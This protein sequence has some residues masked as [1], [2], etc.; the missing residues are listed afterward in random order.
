MVPEEEPDP[1]R[2]DDVRLPELVASRPVEELR[3]RPVVEPGSWR[4]VFSVDRLR[5]ALASLADPE[6]RVVPY[7]L[8]LGKDE[9]AF[10]YEPT[11]DVPVL[12]AP[13]L[14]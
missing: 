1:R 8:P 5:V 4:V 11:R 3:V 9:A 2:V 13:V 7:R 10:P 6:L 12:V 14:R